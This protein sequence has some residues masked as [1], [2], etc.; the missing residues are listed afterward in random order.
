MVVFYYKDAHGKASFSSAHRRC[1]CSTAQTCL[2]SFS[3]F[4]MAY[5]DDKSMTKIGGNVHV[6]VTSKNYTCATDALNDKR[7]FSH[8]CSTYHPRD[9]RCCWIGS[10]DPWTVILDCSD[11]L[12]QSAH[13]VWPHRGPLS[14]DPWDRGSAHQRDEAVGSHRHRL[15]VHRSYLWIDAGD[16]A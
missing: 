2:S 8:D 3:C 7:R 13:A 15:C 11:E 1:T 9:S 5:P 12:H 14:S 4:I 6:A 10:T 16:V